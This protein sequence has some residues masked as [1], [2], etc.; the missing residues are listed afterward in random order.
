MLKNATFFF[1][2]KKIAIQNLSKR[3][4]DFKLTHK[5]AIE[6][7]QQKQTSPN[8]PHFMPRK[9]FKKFMDLVV[10]QGCEL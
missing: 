2:R 9:P 8:E 5:K 4:V 3:E 7:T 1:K 6:N 10:C